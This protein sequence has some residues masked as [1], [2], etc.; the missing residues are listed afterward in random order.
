M[1]NTFFNPIPTGE[2][3]PPKNVHAISVSMPLIQDVI[4]YEEQVPEILEVIKSG[5]PR[6]MIYPYLK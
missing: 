5:Y 1:S 4:D 2:T 6:F 3:L